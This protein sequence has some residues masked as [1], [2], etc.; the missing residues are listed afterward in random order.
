MSPTVRLDRR[1]TEKHYF[2]IIVDLEFTLV[3]E[4]KR[5]TGRGRTVALS[6][7][8]LVFEPDEHLPQCDKIAF[9]I[10]WPVRL[11]H[12]VGLRLCGRGRLVG[13]QG[14]RAEVEFTSY[15]FRTCPAAIQR[16]HAAP[17]PR[18]FLALKVHQVEQP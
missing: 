14:G 9:S 3:S 7:R 11:H 17:L 5:I 4:K 12:I 8:A 15:E 10:S 16:R 2:P 13:Y 18:L 6:S 1:K